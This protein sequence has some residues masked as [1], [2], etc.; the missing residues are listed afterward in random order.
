MIW[1]RRIET[2]GLDKIQ[3]PYQ[4]AYTN[5]YAP[6]VD[7]CDCWVRYYLIPTKWSFI[8]YKHPRDNQWYWDD[9]DLCV[10]RLGTQRGFQR[11]DDAKATLD[12]IL[13]NN[14]YALLNDKEELEK[15]L[16]LI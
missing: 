10:Y 6:I 1:D 2:I 3:R 16:L 12:K 13:V 11:V 14:G 7:K 15:W 9:S 8:V 4:Y 5:G